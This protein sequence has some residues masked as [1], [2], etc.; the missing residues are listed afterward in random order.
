MKNKKKF[1][2]VRIM[3]LIIMGVCMFQIVRD[4]YFIS[5]HKVQQQKLREIA[6]T[7]DTEISHN[8]KKHSQSADFHFLDQYM[9]LYQ[10]NPDLRGWLTIDGTE[11]DYPVMQSEDNDYY[12]EHSFYGKKNK[13]GCLFV[14]DFVDINT[15][16]TNFIVYGHNMK[17]GAMFG[18]L[19]KFQSEEYFKEHSE[20]YFY[21]FTEIRIYD[22]MAA[23]Q[24]KL[25]DEEEDFKYYEFYQE[26]NQ[27]QFEYFY[28]NVMDRALYDTGMTAEFGD[29]FI[30]L[31]TCAYQANDSRF[32]L[33]GKLRN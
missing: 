5:E 11:I 31:S 1:R 6:G 28:K 20:I 13:Y 8:D 29:S 7:N 23:F 17:D 4:L 15:L 27:E 9:E 24:I 22:I 25:Y 18:T 19:D 10:I 32:V 3:L 2:I 30:T 16:E 26:E 14:K 12:L 33:V 21:T